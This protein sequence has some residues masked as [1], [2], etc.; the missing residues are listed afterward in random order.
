MD[1][2]T[3]GVGFRIDASPVEITAAKLRM[4]RHYLTDNEKA[5]TSFAAGA[6]KAATHTKSMGD[7]SSQAAMGVMAL[8]NAVDDAQ[9]GLRGVVN[10]VPMILA[11]LGVGTGLAGVGMVA[12]VAVNQLALNWD[13]L[14]GKLTTSQ[15]TLQRINAALKEMGDGPLDP[16]RM[17]RRDLLQNRANDL[18]QGGDVFRAAIRAGNDDPATRKSKADAAAEIIGQTLTAD[19]L[20]AMANR[21]AYDKGRTDPTIQKSLRDRLAV[22]PD[23]PFG[24]R[25]MED[26]RTRQGILLEQSR[27]EIGALLKRAQEGD[28]ESIKKLQTLLDNV[29]ESVNLLERAQEKFASIAAAEEELAAQAEEVAR[30][31]GERK[32]KEIAAAFQRQ[33]DEQ[34]KRD[35]EKREDR[36]KRF[37]HDVAMNAMAAAERMDPARFMAAAADQTTGA[38]GV[39]SLFMA[40]RLRARMLRGQTADEAR[41]GFTNDLAA[42]L[43]N[44]GQNGMGP[45]MTQAEAF[46]AA[47]RQ[48]NEM[49]PEAGFLGQQM[50]RWAD[51]QPRAIQVQERLV[52]VQEDIA[53][54]GVV[55]ALPEMR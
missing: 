6:E 48:V 19:L 49:A 30:I 40:Q 47:R 22:G 50:G 52:A 7:K 33:Q 45:M 4:M 8:A 14:T 28:L 15:T 20:D 24:Q 2:Q 12:A 11:G 55:M 10:N 41:A 38:M 13:K 1:D 44:A 21:A 42:N 16:L 3:I 32:K 37:D 34:D 36:A 23:T 43:F 54:R 27:Q 35:R 39:N 18:A 31:E 25:A 5:T 17:F 26:V 53:R 9:Y 51:L 29:D 46:A